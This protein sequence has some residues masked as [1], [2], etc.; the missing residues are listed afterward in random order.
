[1]E[2]SSHLFNSCQL[3]VGLT[4]SVFGMGATLSNFLG[5]MVVQ[6][7]GHIASLTGSLILSTIPILL[8]SFMPETFGMRGKTTKQPE[9][10]NQSS[11]T[12]LEAE[13]KSNEYKTFN[14]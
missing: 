7:F 1:M 14:V 12:D 10:N 4:A 2:L 9:I 8:F 5:Q 11:Y 3:P 13:L 6:H